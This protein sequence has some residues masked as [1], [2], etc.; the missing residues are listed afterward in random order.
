M[1]FGTGSTKKGAIVSNY[2]PNGGRDAPSDENRP[3]WRPQDQSAPAGQ[4]TRG[5]EDDHDY[6]SW[7]DRNQDRP[8]NDRDPNRWEGSRGSELGSADEGRRATER[9]GQGQS[10]Y[11]AGR[12]GEDRAQH[13]QMQN[14]NDMMRGSGSREDGGIGADDRFTGRGGSSGQGGWA[15][16]DRGY[17]PERSG[18]QSGQGGGFEAERG[19]RWSAYEAPQRHAMDRNDMRGQRSTDRPWG[20]QMGG[21]DQHMG[22]QS[23]RADSERMGYQ[24]GGS[25][26]DPQSRGN[27]GQH[28][29]RGSGPHRGKGPAGYQRS[30]ERIRELVSEALA[31]DDQIDASQIQ[32]TVKDGEVT[33]TG[34]VDDRRTRREAEDCVSNVSGVRDVQL[35]L[36]VRDDKPGQGMKSNASQSLTGPSTSQSS[37]QHGSEKS[38]PGTGESTTGQ[39][40]SSAHQAGG[41]QETET[42]QDKKPRA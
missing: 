4:R 42:A 19:A 32:V 14:R 20:N 18:S 27:F 15:N 26:D 3:S 5:N 38:H 8:T 25:Q 30:D 11:S 23:G 9:Y 13:A 41:K 24:G 21:Y 7:R 28:Q 39:S 31:D 10:G 16:E 1:H 40:T 33:L 12:Y 36:R 37:T 35:Q 29:H 6:G 22:Y 2:S 17:N 34:T